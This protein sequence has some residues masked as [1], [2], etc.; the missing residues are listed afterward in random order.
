MDATVTSAVRARRLLARPFVW[1]ILAFAAVYLMAVAG[2]AAGVGVSERDLTDAGIAEKAYYA[3]GLF[4]LG[5]LDLGTP[6][7]GPP[8]ARTLLWSAYFLAPMIT[9]FTILEAVLRLI[10]PLSLWLRPL[11]GHVVLGGGGRL[12][13]LYVRK[14][15]EQ[16]PRRSIV[17]VE[18]ASEGPFL[19]E[20]RDQHR[21]VIVQGDVASDSVLRELRLNRAHRVLL[22]TG[23]DFAN[24][25]AAA[26]I[27]RLAPELARRIV[28]HVSDL[29]FI[30]ETS[31]SSVARGCEIFNGHEFAAKH[32]VQEHLVERFRSTPYR[33][34][35]ILAGFGRFGRTVLDQLQR[36]SPGR[37]GPV[38]VVDHD[39]TRNARTFEDEPGFSVDYERVVIDGDVLDPEIWA[40]VREALGP[41]SIAPVIIV[42]SG[43]DGTNLQAALAVCRQH[44]TAYVVVR[45]FRTSPFT[46]EIAREA[47]AHP[48]NLGGL[49][50]SGMPR[51]W[52]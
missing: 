26:K 49:I 36:H 45:S 48:V 43:H 28:V 11:T 21:A 24:L 37:F 14:L 3:L 44:P 8:W 12:T 4:V 50:Q 32:L 16:H 9:A 34:P 46:E 15:R 40:R 41:G 31:G 2:L 47:G 1:R 18:R 39:A 35:I 7:G 19:N 23:D 10:G 6:V 38:V 42:G 5:G 29:G 30:R 22:L 52:F 33:D 25:D 13:L 20:L 27:L 17:V 51:E